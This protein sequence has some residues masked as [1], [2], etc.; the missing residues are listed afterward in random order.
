MR[1]Y[2]QPIEH[3]VIHCT[4][5]PDAST[6]SAQGTSVRGDVSNHNECIEG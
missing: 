5:R 3:S 2:K 6:S 4:V 1:G